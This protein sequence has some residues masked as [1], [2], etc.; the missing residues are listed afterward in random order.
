MIEVCVSVCL[1]AIEER[2][3]A[4]HSWGSAANLQLRTSANPSFP[5][6]LLETSSERVHGSLETGYLIYYSRM[7][8]RRSARLGSIPT[9][10]TPLLQSAAPSEATR[11]QRSAVTKPRKTPTKSNKSD[12]KPTK[13]KPR[14]GTSYSVSYTHLTLPTICSV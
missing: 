1:A 12:K 14:T 7:S 9:I 8:L 6:N 2:H 5:Y 13:T 11:V 10:K 3:Y 4:W